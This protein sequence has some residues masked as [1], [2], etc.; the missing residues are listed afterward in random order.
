MIRY[1]QFLIIITIIS[2]TSINGQAQLLKSIYKPLV[3]G[4][5]YGNKT[6]YYVRMSKENTTIVRAPRSNYSDNFSV[7]RD[8]YIVDL[9]TNIKYRLLD[10]VSGRCYPDKRSIVDYAWIFEP[11]PVTCS[12][13]RLVD[14][15]LNITIN[16]DN[17][18]GRRVIHASRNAPPAS[19]TQ[20][21]NDIED[22][23]S[24]YYE[25]LGLDKNRGIFYMNK[26]SNI[27]FSKNGNMLTISC[28]TN[29]DEFNR[30]R[31]IWFDITQ[32][33][34]I[35]ETAYG[36]FQGER[37]KGAQKFIHIKCPSGI[38]QR[39]DIG[40]KYP[41]AS[42]Y[43]HTFNDYYFCT[44]I[45]NL[46]Q[47]FHNGLLW[48]KQVTINSNTVYKGNLNVSPAGVTPVRKNE[49]NKQTQT[50]KSS[51]SAYQRQNST[52]LSSTNMEF[53]PGN[54][55]IVDG[56]GTHDYTNYNCPSMYVTDYNNSVKIS[57]GGDDVT[58]PKVSGNTYRMTGSSSKG[59]LT[60]TAYRSSQT[61]KIYLVT[62][63]MRNPALGISQITISFK[64]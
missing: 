28:R 35:E 49:I 16:L 14:G 52:D 17:A 30:Y 31:E 8:A 13:I 55:S 50:N 20:I 46:S 27:K 64:P 45:P 43:V 23:I 24:Q 25:I 29:S 38:F 53:R 15:P 34:F 11:L 36:T 56:T 44:S 7:Y 6:E 12:N 19:F 60:L 48:L 39:D 21:T 5:P 58:L 1:Y 40:A 2:F 32:A 10:M 22:L 3:Y 62:A 51:S 26:I 18:N 63:F 54:A 37:E 59:N 4:D 41:V 33:T 42:P 47:Q 61:G 57:W 9:S